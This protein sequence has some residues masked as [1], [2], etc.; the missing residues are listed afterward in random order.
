MEF[1]KALKEEQNMILMNEPENTL[2]DS[3]ATFSRM[4]PINN[5]SSLYSSLSRYKNDNIK[6][7][8]DFGPTN[9]YSEFPANPD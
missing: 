3:V 7:L 5:K 6:T 1:E 4:N 9:K 2:N 8:R